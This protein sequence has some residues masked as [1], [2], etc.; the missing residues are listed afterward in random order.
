MPIERIT[1]FEDNILCTVT[2]TSSVVEQWISSIKRI[3]HRHLNNLIIGLDI[4]WRPN[5]RRGVNN[6]VAILQ[7]C[8]GRRCLIFQILHCDRI[9]RSLLVFLNDRNYTFVGVGIEKDVDK[10]FQDYYLLVSGMKN[11]GFL[12][13]EKLDRKELKRSGLKTLAWEVLGK[14]LEKPQHITLS[15]WDDYELSYDQVHYACID[16]FVSFE[17]GR[18]LICEYD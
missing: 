17:I 11:L 12:A 13:A 7:L 4:E 15:H 8:V 5:F 6:P 3:H 1:F 14:E 16:A 18:T 10:L 2:S 9:P